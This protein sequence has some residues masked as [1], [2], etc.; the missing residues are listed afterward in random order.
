MDLAERLPE[1]DP[2]ALVALDGGLKAGEHRVGGARHLGDLIV[3]HVCDRADVRP[4]DH[5]QIVVRE[6]GESGLESACA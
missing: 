6:T 5:R 1:V 4:D 3:A 2:G